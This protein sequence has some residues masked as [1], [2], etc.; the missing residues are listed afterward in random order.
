MDKL[1]PVLI[2]EQG[3]IQI[4]HKNGFYIQY[5]KAA[6]SNSILCT[7]GKLL[8]CMVLIKPSKEYSFIGF[9]VT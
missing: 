7:H 9:Q 5:V 8:C 4:H 3:I 1:I 2:T 6:A